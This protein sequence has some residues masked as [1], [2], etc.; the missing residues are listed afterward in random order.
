MRT[1]IVSVSEIALITFHLLT[2]GLVSEI[3]MSPHSVYTLRARVV[4]CDK[5]LEVKCP[6]VVG[7]QWPVSIEQQ[8]PPSLFPPSFIHTS[9]PPSPQSP[10]P[11][12]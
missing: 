9:K 3:M 11:H 4:C 6:P 12:P 10:R 5:G 7:P 8:R 2:L 1:T